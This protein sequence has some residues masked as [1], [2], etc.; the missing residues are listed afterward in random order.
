MNTLERFDLRER[1]ALITGASS[2]GIGSGAARLLA[3]CGARVFLVARR[4]ERLSEIAEDIKADGGTAAYYAGDTS[5]E[6]DCKGAVE[7]CL[8]QFGHLDIM[9]LSAGISGLSASGG[10]DNIFDSDNWRNVQSTNLD[11]IFY[12]IKHG[13]SEC[14]KG[15]HGA[16]VP[17][18][19]LAAWYASGNAAYTATKGAIRS[20]THYFGKLFGPLEVRIN[21]FY[22][23]FIDTDMTHRALENEKFVEVQMGKQPLKRIGTIEDCAY[24]ILYLASD[25]SSFMTGQHL[26]VDGGVLTG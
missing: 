1:V 19:S 11:S 4:E 2:K 16:I 23:G 21:T 9:V 24:T 26:I 17:V 8:K 7:A 10:M 18:A 13:Y 15:G 25:A 20:M 12:M 22:P 3:K 6:N 5:R 14:A